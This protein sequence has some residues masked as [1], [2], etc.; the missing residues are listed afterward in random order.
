MKHVTYANV[1]ATLALVFSMSSGALAAKHYLITS[2]SQIKPTVLRSLRG[3]EGP[4]G[5]AGLQ[6]PPGP[7]GLPGLAGGEA[8]LSKLCSAIQIAPIQLSEGTL[9]RALEEI[10]RDGC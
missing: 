3:Q 7:Q 6:G 2:T 10:G 4:R 1:A 5:L 9:K 8:D